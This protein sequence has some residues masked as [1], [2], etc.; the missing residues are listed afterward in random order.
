MTRAGLLLHAV[1]AAS[2]AQAVGTPG[3]VDAP[4]I[5]PVAKAVDASAKTPDAPFRSTA[6]ALVRV[7]APRPPP[8]RTFRLKNG[9]RVLFLP[10]PSP[11]VLSVEVVAKAGAH[12]LGAGVV[13]AYNVWTGTPH[14]T[15]DEMCGM[16]DAELAQRRAGAGAGSLRVGVTVVADRPD[17]AV[18]LLGEVATSPSF[19]EQ[20][21]VRNLSIA[22][23]A[24]EAREEAPATVAG[25]VFPMALFAWSHPDDEEWALRSEDVGALSRKDVVDA[26]ERT[27]DP[28]AASI[29][30]VGAADEEALRAMLERAFGSWKGH[31]K[32]TAAIVSPAPVAT[33]SP[34]VVVVDR[35]SSSQ[36][37]VIFGG[38]GPGFASP[39]WVP[40]KFVTQILGGPS[41]RMVRAL[42]DAEF[43]V[44]H[45]G[46]R[47]ATS[48]AGPRVTFGTDV[49]LER[50][51]ALLR[52]M[53]RQVLA[54]A[55][56]G[57]SDAEV[58]SARDQLLRADGEWLMTHDQAIR[59][60]G[61]LAERDLPPE[62]LD[63][64]TALLST[65]TAADVRRAATAYLDFTRMKVVVVGD[66]SRMRD[67]LVGLGWGPIELRNGSGAV[68]GLE[69]A[70]GPR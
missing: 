25:R 16:L 15:Y 38:A 46:M 20:M 60:L 56:E 11:G 3:R 63:K 32:R 24:H 7:E 67:Q 28:S 23:H 8:I 19:P 30:V 26:Y 13:A 43:A 35:P 31:G 48:P 53:Q 39:D 69:A 54:M 18:S 64:I 61:D 4:T 37:Y 22:A 70:A 12:A 55:A 45:A 1:L 36:A 6:P 9:I 27:F 66:W 62:T 2:C 42:R 21:V 10:Q 68:V 47:M 57:S 40:M 44:T 17:E 5:A 41:G 34:R 65:T 29:V 52:E 33:T 50:T 49:P 59:L 51:G 58:E 14:R